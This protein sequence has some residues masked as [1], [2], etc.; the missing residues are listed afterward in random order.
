MGLYPAAMQFFPFGGIF[1]MLLQLFLRR[2][3]GDDGFT[4]TPRRDWPGW[5]VGL[6]LLALLAGVAALVWFGIFGSLPG[7]SRTSRS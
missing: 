2:S 3:L 6:V 4:E 7:A 1:A 5:L